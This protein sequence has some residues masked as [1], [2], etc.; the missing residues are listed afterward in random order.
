MSDGFSYIGRADCGCIRA[1]CVD[2]EIVGK[3]DVAKAIAKMVRD[4]LV[5]SRVTIEEVRSDPTW[6][7]CGKCE[8]KRR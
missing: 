2:N 8:R 6:K 4:G 3:K 1:A 5:V 7:G